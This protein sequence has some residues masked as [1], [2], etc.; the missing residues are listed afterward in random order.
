MQAALLKNPLSWLV[1]IFGV[2][3]LAI[4]VDV[5][6]V[7]SA[8]Y[9]SMSA[10]MLEKGNFL[11]FTDRDKEYLDKPPFI[12]WITGFFF[13]V[14]GI[15]EFAFKLPSILFSLLG[16][17]ATYRL[18]R[19]YYSKET[20]FLAALILAS[21]QGYFHFNNDVR[22]DTYLTNSVIA[23]VWLI[24]EFLNK[25]KL[26]F[27]LGGFFFAGLAMLAKGPMGLV[28][29]IAA[30]GCHIVIK[31][32][33]KKV[34]RWEWITGIVVL[35]A[36]LSP[37]LYGLYRQFDMQPEK[38]VNGKQGVS[39]IRFYFWEQSF[40]RI[41]GENVWKNDTGPLFF[42]HNLAWSFMPWSL[43]IFGAFF[44]LLNTL[45][46]RASFLAS[47]KEWIS[48]GGFLLPFIA[49][50]MSKYKLPHYIYVTFPFAAILA[51]DYFYNVLL[52]STKGIKWAST[53]Q[54]AL[55]ILVWILAICLTFICFFPDTPMVVAAIFALFVAS[56]IY[57][58]VTQEAALG[59]RFVKL[60]LITVIGVNA[61][62]ALHIY[63]SILNYQAG[64][65]AAKFALENNIPLD[66]LFVYEVNGRSLDVYTQ[67]VQKE[68]SLAG[69]KH[70]L[71]TPKPVFVFT[72]KEG[73]ETLKN[74]GVKAEAVFKTPSYA[75]TLLTSNFINPVTRADVLNT[76]Y[77]VRIQ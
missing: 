59:Q 34:A 38:W 63:P 9:F 60:S 27:C 23:S 67:H 62:L 6:E 7:D 53:I 28:A 5:M 2:Y 19:V 32:E 1:A 70:E 10:E 11:E 16:I 31:G 41:T 36:V 61:I 73:F 22:T 58:L 56:F 50:S 29:P 51:A 43:L 15:G 3:C 21:T 55:L 42:V 4:P 64:A 35:A 12:F 52:K 77:I 17:Y 33:W 18:S 49:L 71:L 8:Q 75:V 54:C 13:Y 44:R 40:G 76:G 45:R 46:S 65:P 26:L 14:L 47:R 24:A 72:N 20:A 37:M 68:I 48:W 25:R 30:F 74:L 57:I 66:R 69:I 39:G